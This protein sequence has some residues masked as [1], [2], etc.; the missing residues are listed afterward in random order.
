MNQ[1]FTT[2]IL[3]LLLSFTTKGQ[4]QNGSVFEKRVS[5]QAE[6]QT[7]E[8]ILKEISWQA[9]VYF[10]YNPKSIGAEQKTS[11]TA[12]NKSL[13]Y[14]LN[15]LFTT[16][17]FT[18]RERENYIII[19]PRKQKETPVNEKDSLQQSFFF[20]KG[21]L[22][23]ERRENPIPY[24]SVSLLRK[25]IGTISNTDGNFLL[26]LSPDNIKNTVVI[27]C[28]GYAQIRM[29]AF[30]LLDKDLITLKSISIRLKEVQVTSI[31]T[32][33]LLEN[34]RNNIADNYPSE[35]RLM[36]AFYRETLQQDKSYINVSEAVTELLKAPYTHTTRNDLVRLVKA[37]KSPNV[38]PLR[39]I[40]FKL[41]GGPFTI[42]QLDVVKTMENFI[43]EAGQDKYRYHITKTIL[44]KQHP[45]YVVTF[46]PVFDDVFPGYTG[47]MYVH[48]GTFAI[49]HISFRFTKKSLKKATSIM[50]KKKPRK[51]KVRPLYAEYCINYR[52]YRGKWYL[53]TV[54]SSVKF[55]V[56]SKRD[57][58][59]SVFHSISD[60]LITD[61][62]P[63]KLKKFPR[64]ERFTV[65]DIFVEQLGT[66][67]EK[68]WENYNIIQPDEDLKKVFKK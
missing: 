59:N 58:L 2:G 5:V 32:K 68:F 47:K 16:E 13:Y 43:S 9:G 38:K 48:R 55:R 22:I 19:S 31:P 12:H 10:S 1:L 8:H 25:P 7:I 44:Y 24:A 34:I 20:L 53:S 52:Q 30:E 14:I 60:L 46:S 29:P 18:L 28:M 39:W 41:Q 6:N 27:S 33:N 37:R 62:H 63:T 66:F 35:N 21:K 56:K 23:D 15:Q 49:L 11:I 40:D 50:I 67:D 61:I 57:K 4:Q 65:K 54:H 42:V 64:N 26:K 36:T 45:V 51:T 17:N 3:I